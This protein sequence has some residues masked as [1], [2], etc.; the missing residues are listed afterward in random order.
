MIVLAV[1]R[2]RVTAERVAGGNLDED[3]RDAAG[4]LDE[5]LLVI[6]IVNSCADVLAGEG[7]GGFPGTPRGSP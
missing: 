5:E 7:L 4:V 3:D 1:R 6:G 2:S